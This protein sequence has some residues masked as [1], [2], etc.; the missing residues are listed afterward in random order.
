MSQIRVPLSCFLSVANY[1]SEKQS[2]M[3]Q[4]TM[5]IRISFHLFSIL[6]DFNLRRRVSY[7]RCKRIPKTNLG[8][9]NSSSCSCIRF[10]IF[11]WDGWKFRKVA[12]IHLSSDWRKTSRG[13]PAEH[14]IFATLFASFRSQLSRRYL[15]KRDR[16]R[17]TS[18]RLISR[19][20]DR[21][22][23]VY[24]HGSP[25]RKM[26]AADSI[27]GSWLRESWKVKTANSRATAPR[28]AGTSSPVSSRREW[29]WHEF[30]TGCAEHLIQF[31]SY[32]INR[33]RN[34]M[35]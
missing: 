22:W 16:C 26:L 7:I 35:A 3:Y 28:Q 29:M 2:H 15:T 32:K 24:I 4:P 27:D 11:I 34:Q 8:K 14:R 5:Y 17:H 12:V 21:T 9:I 19:R 23:R 20:R 31:I 1:P 6:K 10:F 18:P 30:H 33:R 13:I 25:R